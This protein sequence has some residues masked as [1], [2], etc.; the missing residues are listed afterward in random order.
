MSN[1]GMKI[2][3]VAQLPPAFIEQ[4]PAERTSERFASLS[5]RTEPEKR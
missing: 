2:Q 5:A 3:F 1:S 4:W